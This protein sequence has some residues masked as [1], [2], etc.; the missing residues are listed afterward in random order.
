M[1]TE[2]LNDPAFQEIPCVNLP[3]LAAADNYRIGQAETRPD[4]VVPVGVTLVALQHLP[5]ALVHQADRRVEGRHEDGIAVTR[6]L[7]GGDGL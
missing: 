5:V 1:G 4:P 2:L 7:D 6:L 3:I